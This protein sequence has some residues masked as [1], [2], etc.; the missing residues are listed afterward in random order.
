MLLS[1]VGFSLRTSRVVW[2]FNFLATGSRLGHVILE[3]KHV[4][5]LNFECQCAG[6][7]FSTKKVSKKYFAQCYQIVNIWYQQYFFFFATLFIVLVQSFSFFKIFLPDTNEGAVIEGEWGL[8][9][10]LFA[11][12]YISI[13]Y[14]FR[15]EN[16][17]TQRHARK[18][19]L[20]ATRNVYEYAI[21]DSKDC[22]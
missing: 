7:Q 18:G 11:F 19:E 5:C 15:N 13:E 1:T 10:L 2:I 4:H 22:G 6:S 21:W 3:K 12:S 17:K 20:Y 14:K 9:Q 16:K 8:L